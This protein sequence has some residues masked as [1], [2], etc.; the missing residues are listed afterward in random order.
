MT[1]KPLPPRLSLSTSRHVERAHTLSHCT[2]YAN[3][4]PGFDAIKLFLIFTLI[5]F[6]RTHVGIR[7]VL[8]IRI[9]TAYS[10]EG[11]VH[12]DGLSHSTAGGGSRTRVTVFA[13]FRSYRFFPALP[14]ECIHATAIPQC[15]SS[16]DF[17]SQTSLRGSSALCLLRCPSGGHAGAASENPCGRM[18]LSLRGIAFRYRMRKDVRFEKVCAALVGADLRQT[19]HANTGE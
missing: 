11:E 18:L 10:L 2:A 4:F 19:S 3:V 14:P 6:V 7:S 9:G 1:S 17:H 5:S 15:C 13:A 16:L 8:L 12:L